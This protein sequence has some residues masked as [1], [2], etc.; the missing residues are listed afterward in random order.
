MLPNI[1]FQHTF[2]SFNIGSNSISHIYWFHIR[3]ILVCGEHGSKVVNFSCGSSFNPPID[4]IASY[5]GM[6]HCKKLFWWFIKIGLN[7]AST[8]ISSI[9]SSL[10]LLS[11]QSFSL[12]PFSPQA[13][14]PHVFFKFFLF[15]LWFFSI[16]WG[17]LRAYMLLF[18]IV[19]LWLVCNAFTN[20]IYT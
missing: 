13:K 2:F 7:R 15:G 10:A 20:E 19:V 16:F 3:N 6:N 11:Q 4:T 9:I 14:L 5:V 8:S 17:V 1:L 18:L 12:C